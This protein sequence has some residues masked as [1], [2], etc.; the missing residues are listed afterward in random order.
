[1]KHITR[2]GSFVVLTWSPLTN[3]ALKW[4]DLKL[5]NPPFPEKAKQT[6]L[7][8]MEEKKNPVNIFFSFWEKS[9]GLGDLKKG[10]KR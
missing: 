6:I 4:D 3:L 1:M 8:A 2:K 9:W 7:K 5:I 10:T